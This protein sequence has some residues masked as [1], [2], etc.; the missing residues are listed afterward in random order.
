MTS[1]VVTQEELC[2][3]PEKRKEN[4]QSVTGQINDMDTRKGSASVGNTEKA[5]HKADSVQY[6]ENRQC[7][8]TEKKKQK[9][10]FKS[11]ELD[12][13]A[14]LNTDAKLKEA[15]IKFF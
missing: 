4:R 8:K 12:M 1:C 2:Q 6:I 13:N 10:I 11:F 15:V 9:F 14:I 7:Y 3:Q 5:G